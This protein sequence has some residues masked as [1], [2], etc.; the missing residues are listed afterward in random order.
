[1]AERTIGGK[2]WIVDTF[3]GREELALFRQLTALF[4][5]P[6]T[7][8]ISDISNQVDANTDL[9][10][11]VILKLLGGV[12]GVAG[13]MADKLDD[14]QFT[15]L[16]QRLLKST[17]CRAQ[18]RNLNAAEHMET[19][20]KGD[21]GTLLQVLAFVV[22]VNFIGPFASSIGPA[23]SMVISKLKEMGTTLTSPASSATKQGT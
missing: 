21:I 9:D 18:E 3:G 1:M 19:L 12:V 13:R 23:V 20:F 8:A 22:E 5:V 17:I 15:A 2:V 6:F 4:A 16:A 7:E 10:A 14:A 11:T